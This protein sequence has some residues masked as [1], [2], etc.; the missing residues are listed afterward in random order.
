MGWLPRRSPKSQP[1]GQRLRDLGS[2]KGLKIQKETKTKQKKHL[3]HEVVGQC[4]VFWL[5]VAFRF[6]IP[7]G[8][9]NRE[10]EIRYNENQQVN[11]T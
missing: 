8:P 5:L 10:T 4:L 11:Q 3:R 1:Q 9:E 2:Q 6:E 7:R